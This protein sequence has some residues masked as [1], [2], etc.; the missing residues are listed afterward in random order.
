MSSRRPRRTGEHGLFRSCCVGLV[1]LVA[2]CVAAAVLL[3]RATGT[4]AL[5]PGPAGPADGGSTQTIAATLASEVGSRLTHP[6][7]TGAVVLITEQD[8]TVLAA[9]INPD[10]D[11]F[12]NVQVRARG[13]QL[14]LTADSHVG[15]LPVAVTAKLT[16]SL[17]PDGSISP[18]F[19]ELDIG[20]QGLPGFMRSAVDPRGDAAFSLAALLNGT[21]LGQFGLECVAVLPGR[22]LELGFHEPL[23]APSNG[24]CAAHQL[25]PG[26]TSA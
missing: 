21:H 24:Y 17:L 22:G 14:W 16:V 20:D 19:H 18:D 2:L 11:T 1:V 6:G 5:G 15:P 3:I 9:E 4:P 23:A 13:E 26:A 7:A 10:Q 12:T 8:L 25:Q